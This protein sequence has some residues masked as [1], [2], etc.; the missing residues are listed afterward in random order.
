MIQ[1]ALSQRLKTELMKLPIR[2]RL[3]NNFTQILQKH[4]IYKALIFFDKMY[5]PMNEA[6]RREFLT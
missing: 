1:M 5:E 2:V 6:E 4:N 3:N